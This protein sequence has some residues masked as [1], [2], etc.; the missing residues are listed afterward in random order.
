M[1]EASADMR[2]IHQEGRRY[3]W[4]RIELLSYRAKII[5]GLLTFAALVGLTIVVFGK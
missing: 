1:M 2:E 4:R 3:E 5:G